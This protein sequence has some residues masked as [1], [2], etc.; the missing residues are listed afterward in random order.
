[1]LH[2]AVQLVRPDSTPSAPL[3]MSA[4]AIMRNES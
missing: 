1:M 3:T 4:V 2:P